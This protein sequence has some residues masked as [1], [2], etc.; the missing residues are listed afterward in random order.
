MQLV[1]DTDFLSSV[2]K[3]NKLDLVLKFFAENKV[4]I[5]REVV[6]EISKTDLI[7]KVLGSEKIQISKASLDFHNNELDKGELAAIN[8]VLSNKDSVFFTND[9]K[10]KNCAIKQKIKTFDLFSFLL[11]CKEIKFLT[12]QE[13]KQIIKD[14]KKKDYF[15]FGKQREKILLS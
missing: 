13:L 6:E 14:L 11:A 12:N 2:L 8:L 1:C 9:K 15:E 4:I 10:A 5:P 3:I 7:K